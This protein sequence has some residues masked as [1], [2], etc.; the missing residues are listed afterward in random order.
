MKDGHLLKKTSIGK[1]MPHIWIEFMKGHIMAKNLKLSIIIVAFNSKNL[2]KEC[3]DSL[4]KSIPNNLTYEILVMDNAST[5]G[6]FDYIKK[7]FKDIEVFQSDINVG[8]AKANN[9]LI[10]KSKGDYVL[11]LNP[12]TVISDKTIETLVSYLDSHSDVAVVTTKIVL[13]NG[14]MDDASHRGF[15]TPWNAFCHFLGISK[16][17]PNSNLLNGYHLGYK[18]LDKV[19]EIDSGVGA[20][21]L[22]R[23]SAGERVGWLD[24]D[25]FWYGED[26]DFCFRIK[27]KGGKII[28]IPQVS[29]LHYKG[30]SSGIK[31]HSIDLSNV[32]RETKIKATNARF[33]V[34]KIFYKKHYQKRYP[35]WVKG[36][37]LGAI[38]FKRLV[39]L[40][41]I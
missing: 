12:D 35:W 25:Y 9:I 20:C 7:T 33:D 41:K 31:K 32:T 22:I 5:D 21:L 28:Y 24:E 3:V 38:E 8:F 2:I 37:I 1:Q 29:I 30:V 36:L 15:P 19:H 6:S 27:E 13:L 11:L 14:Q 17:F 39:S 34:M 16:L 40:F 4:K 10:K 26:L 18:D 23:R